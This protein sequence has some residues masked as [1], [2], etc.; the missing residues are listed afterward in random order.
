MTFPALILVL[1]VATFCG[2]DPLCAAEATGPAAAP[3][4]DPAAAVRAAMD[5][6]ARAEAAVSSSR[7]QA[8]AFFQQAAA[9]CEE[10]AAMDARFYPAQVLWAHSLQRLA[11]LAPDSAQ[12]TGYA[13][14]AYQRFRV[15]AASPSADWRA[16]YGLGQAV[17]AH[18]PQIATNQQHVVIL[19]AEAYAHLKKAL[20]LAGYTSEIS[21]VTRDLGLCAVQYAL[22]HPGPKR[23]AEL[24]R[25]GIA[26]FETTKAKASALLTPRVHSRWGVALLQLAK[27]DGNDRLSIRLAIDQLQ[28]TLELNAQDSETRYN[29]A[30]AYALL[31]QPESAMRHLRICLAHDPHRIYYNAAAGDP[32][33]HN[34]RHTAEYNRIFV[35]DGTSV[36][37]PGQP[38]LS[39]Q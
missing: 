27:M 14:A 23:R 22:V 3:A 13:R 5:L 19:L 39:G 29:L 34:L 12:Q 1:F 35:D 30:C 18:T 33:L 37:L 36:L 26:R 28:K 21:L 16:H 8:L 2:V 32:D 7:E 17:M 25:D 31:D 38:T 10:A 9:R 11:Q 15:A 20:D 24:F 6:Q 4:S